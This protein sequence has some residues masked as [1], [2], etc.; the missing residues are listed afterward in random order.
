MYRALEQRTD[1]SL[2]RS[3]KAVAE[4]MQSMK[5]MYQHIESYDARVLTTAGSSS[6]DR[7]K[8]TWFDLTNTERRQ[9]RCVRV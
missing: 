4:K 1:G 3:H 9:L 6:D 7:A 2:A 5:E 8:R